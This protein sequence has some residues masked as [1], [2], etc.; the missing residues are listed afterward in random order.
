MKIIICT[1]KSWNIKNVLTLKNEYQ[2][3]HDVYLMTSKE[4]LTEDA[5]TA[6]EPDYVFFPHW[7]NIIPKN[8]FRRWCC[9]VFH[10]TDLPFGRGG[11]PLQNLIVRKIE[12]TKI[13][14]IKVEEGLDTGPVYFKETLCLH[15][16]ADEILIRASNIIF[17]KMI[18]KFFVKSFI[19]SS[20]LGETVLFKRR[21]PEQSEVSI[22]MSLENI[23][24]HIR[25]LD[26]EGYPK[27]YFKLG[28]L[29]F[30]LSRA[31][32]K[33]NEV[34]ADVRIIEEKNE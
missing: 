28:N 16:T 23:Y 6:I 8:I 26:G 9:V 3:E 25:M 34:F 32:Y 27:C 19:P 22:G 7:S 17:K 29:K 30:E 4:E 12:E 31:S 10:M 21:T 1:I 18:P 24:D 20:Q 15:G 11:S 5:L 13:S 33:G 2:N 14:A